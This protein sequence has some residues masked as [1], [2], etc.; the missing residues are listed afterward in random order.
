MLLSGKDKMGDIKLSLLNLTSKI[1]LLLTQCGNENLE[2]RYLILLSKCNELLEKIDTIPQSELEEEFMKINDEFTMLTNQLR[3]MFFQDI[4]DAIIT[5]KTD[6]IK[7][8][9]EIEGLKSKIAEA[10]NSLN[11]LKEE[12]KRLMD[13]L[14]H[15]RSKAAS[16]QETIDSLRKEL[17]KIRSYKEQYKKFLEEKKDLHDY[18]SS[19]EEQVS[20]LKKDNQILRERLLEAE[21][22]YK[23]KI[24]SYERE[25]DQL[26]KECNELRKILVDEINR[27][28]SILIS[29]LRSMLNM[30]RSEIVKKL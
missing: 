28:L 18:I 11:K 4:I 1:K 12:N 13:H 20:S 8:L 2:K 25:I 30:L 19:L 21:K 23:E 26:R 14:S 16:L 7:L 27:K 6:K 17:D 10:E 22:S 9:N 24:E 5:L 29:D 15:E 3:E